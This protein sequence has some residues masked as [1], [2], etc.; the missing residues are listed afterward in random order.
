MEIHPLQSHHDTESF[1]CGDQVL[2]DWF[3]R[4]AKQHIRKGISRSFVAVDAD[5]P[6]RVL[7]FYSLTAGEAETGSL[8][9]ALAKKLP[10]KIP[11]VLLGRLAVSTQAQGNGIGG[12]LLIDA[13]QRAVRVA[14]EVGISAILVDAKNPRAVS[15]YQH[16]GF[17]VLPDSPRRLVLA[18]ATAAALFKG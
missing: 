18:I 3:R 2:D 7:G 12:I 14:A 10:R 4:T 17:Q 5:M 15:F 6:N 11:I 1:S 13:L 8:P 9:A 16:F